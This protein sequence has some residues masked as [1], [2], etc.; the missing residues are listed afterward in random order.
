MPTHPLFSVVIP[1]FNATRT[2]PQT[3]ASLQAQTFGDWEALLVDDGSTDATCEMIAKA[4]AA[5]PR[6]R[7][8]R[9]PR[10]GPSAARN[11]AV[12]QARGQI[13]AFCD[14]DDLWAPQ[15]LAQMADC[16]A[17]PGVDAVFARIA[18]FRD[19]PAD[20]QVFSTVPRDALTIATLLGENPVCTMSNLCIRKDRFV[21]SGG[22]DETL[23]HNEDLEWLIRLVGSGMRITGHD[24][25]LVWYRNNIFGLSANFEA[26]CAGRA[27]A[28]ATARRFGVTVNRRADAVYLR[29]LSRRALRLDAGRMLPL[30]FALRGLVASPTGFFSDIRR[31][32]LTL[33]GALA[34]PVLGHRMRQ[35]LFGR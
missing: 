10:K 35:R 29:Y 18:F 23:V 2:L 19:E 6:L 5:D 13:I 8:L 17:D 7:L 14:A 27:A 24:T 32:G 4:A 1:C 21:A 15:K 12:T 11:H 34:A 25:T 28:I 9:N 22:F 20:A 3:L 16:F 26:M 33:L 30:R 31:G